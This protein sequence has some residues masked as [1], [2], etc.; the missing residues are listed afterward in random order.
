[1]NLLG[2]GL[3]VVAA[4]V[5]AASNVLQRMANRREPPQLQMSLRLVADLVR[6]PV[7]LAGFAAVV[8]SFL[9]MASAL[10]FGQLAVIQPIIILELPLTLIAGA[11]IFGSRLGRREWVAAGV[12]TL[13]LA[14]LIVFLSPRGGQPSVGWVTWT[15]GIGGSLLLVAG[16]VLLARLVVSSDGTRAAVLGAA[17][18]ITF[19]LTAALMK[20][21]TE[22]FSGGLGSIFV[23][24]Q[25][26]AMAVSGLLG[27][28]LLQTALHAGRLIAAQ[29]GITLL[30]PFTAIVWGIVGFGE[31]VRG[32]IFLVLAV[33][34]AGVLAAGALALSR[35][36]LLEQEEG[37]EAGGQPQAA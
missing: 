21:M 18:G 26:Y 25:T 8:L 12:M 24:W 19:G 35:S 13:G 32:G 3:A 4:G 2:I 20:G 29:P 30:D 23:A 36:P 17:T 27:M 14:G 15:V 28:Y 31:Q 22:Q 6:R 34:S 10:G 9:L 5:N 11:R 16:L 7:W 33:V 37:E 1:M